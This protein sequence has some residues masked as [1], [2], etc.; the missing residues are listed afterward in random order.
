VVNYYFGYGQVHVQ[1]YWEEQHI[2]KAFAVDAGWEQYIDPKRGIEDL[3]PRLESFALAAKGESSKGTLLVGVDPFKE[4]DLTHLAK[5]VTAGHYFNGEQGLLVAEGL[6][7]YLK[8]GVG[9]TMVLISQG[10]HG[11]NAAGKYPVTGLVSFGPPELNSQVAFLTLAEAQEFYGAP[12]MATSLV[13]K[14]NNPDNIRAV[15][16]RLRRQLDPEVYE[17]LDYEELMPELIEAKELDEAG[18][19]IIILVL[20]AIIGFGIFG[21][22][23]MMLKE[24][25]YE[26]GIL[27]AI[28]MHTGEINRMVWLETVFLGLIGCL[29]GMAAALPV[30]WYLT[31]NPITFTGEMAE[32]YEKFGVEAVLPATIDPLV[33]GTQAVV[34][35]AMISLMAFYPMWKI[36]QLKPV[37]AMRG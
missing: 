18:G 11:V 12:G 9:D 36:R 14:T 22:L 34:I 15:V 30:V 8:V 4:D 26:F 28:G 2:D 20:Y 33:F 25:E 24:R 13:L 31:V 27:K 16:N 32:A 3:V 23:L 10:Y 37:E 7:E 1:G 21:T 19:T 6:A 5:R 17:V 29:A 35:F